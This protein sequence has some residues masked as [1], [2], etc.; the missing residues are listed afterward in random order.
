MLFV[1]LLGDVLQAQHGHSP[2]GS[3]PPVRLYDGIGSH[4]HIIKTSSPEAQKYFSQ[5]LVLLYGFNHDEALRSFERA[6]QL[7]PKSPMP[8]WGMALVLGANYNDP[9]SGDRNQKAHETIQKALGMIGN[10]PA[11]EQA[12]VKALATRYAAD[13]KADPRGLALAYKN[14]MADLVRRYPDDL[15]AATLYAESLMNLN[16]WKLWTSDG[17]AAE[18][19]EEIIRVL[20]GVLRRNPHHPGANHYFI[21]AV[22]AGPN[23]ERALPSAERLK[24]LVPAAGHL[25][26]MPG[27]IYLRTGD[28]EA[29]AVTN[30]A[31]V[32]SD[33]RMLAQSG[34]SGIYPAMYFNH[35][36]HF[37]AYARAEQ[38]RHEEAMKAA[39]EMAAN[40]KPY[41]KEMAMLEA[42]AA[43][44]LMTMARNERWNEILAEP[45]PDAPAGVLRALWHFSRTLAYA[46]MKDAAKAKAERTKFE[47][48]R[49]SLPADMPWGANNTAKQVFDLAARQLDARLAELN[50]DREKAI[51]LWRDAVRIQDELVYDEP[52]AWYYPVRESL[53]ATLYRAGK[54][55]EAEAM[56][57]ENLDRY[58]RNPRSLF[59]LIEALRAQGKNESVE[60]VTRELDSVWKP[61]GV[62]LNIASL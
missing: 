18:G 60:W 51:A 45:E 20:E 15:D 9:G 61:A 11:P 46:G 50:G 6:A 36:F 53:A 58:P 26:H 56:F 35:N 27:H 3:Q 54:H 34:A 39:R 22:E 55:A 13:P 48:A 7:D 16:P 49:T 31:A 14:A 52:P 38:G 19:T 2:K 41:L 44:P 17:K 12:Y 1:C 25:V 10:V 23:P 43:V 28:F 42:F 47:T 57:R 59:G 24:A 40:V 8:L 33:R 30:V 32:E 21:H 5:G 62:K 37:I 29:A 4:Q